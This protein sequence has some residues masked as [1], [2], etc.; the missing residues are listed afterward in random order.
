MAEQ[1]SWL[2]NL[3]G[4]VSIWKL[5]VDLNDPKFMD[6]R[7]LEPDT[8]G[9]DS[10]PARVSWDLTGLV[11]LRD[12]RRDHPA[13]L[14]KAIA[15]FF[16][17]L[18]KVREQLEDADSGYD[19]YRE[20]F[21]IPGLDVD[22]GG[23]YFYGPESGKL[24]VI[25]WG[26]SP[27]SIQHEQAFLFGYDSFRELY[28][29]EGIEPAAAAAGSKAAAADAEAAPE[30]AAAAAGIAE[31][32]PK[33]PEKKGDEKAEDKK[34]DEGEGAGRPWWVWLLVALGAIALVV[35]LLLLLQQCDEQQN[36]LQ[37]ADAGADA[38]QG[39]ATD[40][41][42]DATAA[43]TAG[44]GGSGGEGGSGGGDPGSGGAGGAGTGGAGTGGAGTGG[45]DDGS[46]GDDSSGGTTPI[47]APGVVPGGGG[48]FG[49]T[50]LVIP[51]GGA[52]SGSGSGTP[53]TPPKPGQ[54]HR[55]HF[56][57]GAIAWRVQQGFQHV[58]S[59]QTEGRTYHVYLKPGATFEKVRVQWQDRN[60]RWHDH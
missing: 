56:H 20:A 39:G 7:L 3:V 43:S 47:P 23:H 37:G 53:P 38:G 55:A 2:P 4:G 45:G 24:Y 21:T 31:P 28:D 19:K 13:E 46:G 58:D 36:A 33:E 8:E 1:E 32:A 60:G 34:D 25:D 59:V 42:A 41:G 10:L 15:E 11:P 12:A 26:A 40:A 16:A 22:D 9:S 5:A 48:T 17:C 35:I 18:E 50:V 52:G 49:G 6:G 30:G 14:E 29:Q 51:G 54:S 44:G 57:P 27:R